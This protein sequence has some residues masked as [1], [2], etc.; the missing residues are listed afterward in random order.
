[1]IASIDLIVNTNKLLKQKLVHV[2]AAFIENNEINIFI[3]L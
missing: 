2:N 3:V 1:M